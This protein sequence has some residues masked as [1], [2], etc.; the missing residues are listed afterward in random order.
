MMCT[1]CIALIT[2]VG[3][4]VDGSLGHQTQT[5]TLPCILLTIICVTLNRNWND[6]SSINLRQSH[7]F[8]VECRL[9]NLS[10][11]TVLSSD[12]S[13]LPHW[14]YNASSVLQHC[15]S[16]TSIGYVY[17]YT[18][19]LFWALSSFIFRLDCRTVQY[20]FGKVIFLLLFFKG[21]KYTIWGLF[22]SIFVHTQ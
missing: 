8:F 20:T 10:C 17:T 1:A 7:P 2:F 6:W 11:C 22:V 5:Q 19:M 12:Y 4:V 13:N 18:S 21:D 14:L 16:A 3:F 9:T 15:Y